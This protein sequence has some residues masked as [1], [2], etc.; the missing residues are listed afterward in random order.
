ML[1]LLHSFVQKE[2]DVVD[3]RAGCINV[4]FECPRELLVLCV[5][6]HGVKY[7]TRN[8]VEFVVVSV[9]FLGRAFDTRATAEEGGLFAVGM[10]TDSAGW[11]FA[12]KAQRGHL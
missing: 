9:Y 3:S 7:I 1:M 12:N 2:F 8:P 6:D 11:F 10:L 4:L 5:A